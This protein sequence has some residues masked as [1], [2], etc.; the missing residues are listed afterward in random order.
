MIISHT[1]K[2]HGLEV[3]TINTLWITKIFTEYAGASVPIVHVF[4]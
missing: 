1:Q 4:S 3:G 2:S